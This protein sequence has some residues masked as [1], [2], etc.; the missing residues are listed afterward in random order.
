MLLETMK[1][2]CHIA[3][4]DL[5][6]NPIG[7]EGASLLARYLRNNTLPNL[8]R[9]SLVECGTGDDGFIAPVSALEQNTSLLQL[10][11]GQW[12]GFS[13]RTFLAL[14]KSLPE[15]KFLQE[16]DFDWSE[17]LGS[18]M[19]LLLAGLHKSTCLF[20][21]VA[22]CAPALVSPMERFGYRN[23]FLP[24]I[25]ASKERISPLGV[26]PYALARVATLP[27][28]IFEVIRSKPNLVPS[29]DAEGKEAAED[30]GVPKKRKRGDE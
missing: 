16:I 9:L 23:R 30:T 19:P 7:N 14:A 8:T 2:N 26:W 1:H 15:T 11:L 18:A 3:D 29:E 10:D 28:V 22:Y 21:N 17:G 5:Q 20:L 4:L 13:E 25:R 12:H 24:L 6:H 27:D